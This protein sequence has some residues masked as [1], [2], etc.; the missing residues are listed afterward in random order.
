MGRTIV[1]YERSNGKCPFQEWLHNL[2]DIKG[3]AAIR[4]R[5]ERVGLGNLGDCKSVGD[6]VS[7]LRISYGPGYRVYFGQEG[8]KLVVLLCGGDKS[9]QKR[10][11]TKA[12][13]LWE[14][15]K[16]ASKKLSK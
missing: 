9:T 1:I 3:R 14:E 8:S 5:I 7:E 4:A 2:K 11:I 10:D 6:G 15:Y 16:N 12:K 13:E